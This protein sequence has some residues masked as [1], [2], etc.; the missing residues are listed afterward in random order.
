VA[1]GPGRLR[2]RP[3]DER[4]PGTLLH[5]GRQKPDPSGQGPP[6]RNPDAL[7]QAAA[8][9]KH[10]GPVHGENSVWGFEDGS[11][12]KIGEAQIGSSAVIGEIVQL[13]RSFTMAE[14]L[15][16]IPTRPRESTDGQVMP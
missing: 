15:Q 9:R 7:R 11:T 14:V 4:T 8:S 1:L 5:Y 2:G 13:F 12:F 6:D 3:H 16:R 10:E